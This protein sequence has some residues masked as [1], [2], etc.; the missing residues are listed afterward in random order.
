[1]RPTRRRGWISACLLAMTAPVTGPASASPLAELAVSYERLERLVVRLGMSAEAID[2]ADEA[3]ETA[4]AMFFGRRMNQAAVRLDR[5]ALTMLG[6]QDDPAAAWLTSLEPQDAVP[7]TGEQLV[8]RPRAAV[9]TPPRPTAG[10]LGRVR[11]L[12]IPDGPAEGPER[13]LDIQATGTIAAAAV[14]DGAGGR[15]QLDR[16]APDGAYRVLAALPGDAD[17]PRLLPLGR[18]TVARES[19]D[20]ERRRLEVMLRDAALPD[21]PALRRVQA[22]LELLRDEPLP[23]NLTGRVIDRIALREQLRHEVPD[24]LAGRDPHRNRTGDWWHRLEVGAAR[25]P[26]RILVPESVRTPDAANAANAPPPPLLIALHG[27]GGNEHLFLDGHGGGRLAALAE[28][29]GFIVASPP[30]TALALGGDFAR[31]LEVIEEIHAF[32]RGRVWLIGH[33]LGAMTSVALSGLEPDR[34]AAAALIAGGGPLIPPAG[35][36]IPPLHYFPAERDR[37]IPPGRVRAAGERSRA[38]GVPTSIT[39]ARG[40]GHVLV[41][42]VVLEDAVDWLRQFRRDD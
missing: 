26:T 13:T 42:S 5:A 39:D 28:R 11:L 8:L 29:H 40:V 33:S 17:A 27:A 36:A 6:L 20:A 31:L 19:L 35:V 38:A 9:A 1:M 34:I 24:L 3:L 4:T 15:V 41:V 7:G 16:A 30:T 37:I 32:D 14:E 22:R 10:D 25:W 12:L 23:G 18:W 2:T 21:S